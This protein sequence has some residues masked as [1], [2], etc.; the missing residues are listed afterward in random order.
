MNRLLIA[1]VVVVAL[2]ALTALGW[3]PWWW[4]F[5]GVPEVE[6][7]ALQEQL[8]EVQVLDVRTRGEFESGHIEGAIHVPVQQIDAAL[9]RL[10][11]DRPV[12]A[13][14]ASAHRSIPAV[15]RLRAAG[16]EATQLQGG[17]RAWHRAGLETVR[18]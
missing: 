17:M 9:D 10:D 6:A 8:A 1:A 13:V 4:P 16:F 18:P 3:M 14:C 11:P 7:T 15:R 12:V 2:V 5:G